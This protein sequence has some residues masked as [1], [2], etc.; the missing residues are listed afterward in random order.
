MTQ[1]PTAADWAVF[2]TFVQ[3]VTRPSWTAVHAW[4]DRV[5][6][7]LEPARN[8]LIA[9]RSL[10]NEALRDLGGDPSLHDW[11][12]F[13]SIRRDREEDWSDWLAQ[14]IKDSRTGRFAQAL[15]GIADAPEHPSAYLATTVD[16]EVAVDGCRAD[17]IIYWSD[18]RYTHVEVK[19][20]DPSLAK[21]KPTADRVA[22]LCGTNRR[23]SD[24]ILLLPEQLEHWSQECL[25]DGQMA[26]EIRSITW[27]QVAQSL[28]RS[29][30][31]AAQEPITW[32]VWAHA[33]CG[34][35]EQ[36]LLNLPANPVDV[37][38]AHSLPPEVLMTV[39]EL[40]TASR[41]C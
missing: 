38:W 35:V 32:R 28:R 33:F 3:P 26:I 18:G 16:R 15:L 2:E 7:L 39:Q 19:V 34:C 11:T 9:L 22:R 37:D 14:L 31:E 40:L 27:A 5:D 6:A 4:T 13:R 21:T 36:Q 12:T 25:R 29:L 1:R 20:G 10:S 17:L 30:P 41:N 23:R 8:R 24:F